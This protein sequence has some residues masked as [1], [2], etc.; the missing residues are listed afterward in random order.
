MNYL[1]SAS[2]D[3][4]IKKTTN[5]DSLTVKTIETDNGY[6]AFAVMC[7]GMGGLQKGEL[8]SATVVKAFTD[9]L[10]MNRNRIFRENME[11]SII[12]NEWEQLV[13]EQ[14]RKIMDYGRRNGVSLGTTATVMLLTEYRYYIL[15]VGDSRAYEI[16][17]EIR[18]LT[19]DQTVVAR[20]VRFG[21]MTEEEARQDLRRNVLL[22][23]IGASGDVYPDMFF[24]ETKKDAVYMLCSD[25]FRHQITAEE[26]RSMLNPSVLLDTGS[27]KRSEEYLIDLNKRRMETDNISIVTIR[28]F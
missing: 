2:T 7:D 4:G 13:K 16:T 22:Q 28:T 14:N 27:M 10:Y 19:E 21:R 18:Q 5:Q 20:E 1:V 23:C 9:W 25:G 3:V 6:F 26:I 8:A 15:N 11:D 12:R 24:G 17:E